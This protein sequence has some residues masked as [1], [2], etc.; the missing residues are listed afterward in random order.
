MKKIL[1]QE[2]I[3]N[4]HGERLDLAK[5]LKTCLRHTHYFAKNIQPPEG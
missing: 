5:C 4:G 1:T 2:R 3:T